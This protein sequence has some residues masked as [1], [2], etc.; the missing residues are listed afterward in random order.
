MSTSTHTEA[1]QPSDL[2]L[3]VDH[4][5]ALTNA[6]IRRFLVNHGL[7]AG[8]SKSDLRQNINEAIADE[9]LSEQEV[10]DYLDEVTPWG[11][12]H[13]FLY[14]GLP[15]ASHDQWKKP[16][17]VRTHL[18]KVGLSS[19]VDAP[20]N[21]LVLPDNLKVAS[22]SYSAKRL[23]VVAVRK[24][25]GWLRDD[26]YDDAGEADD[27]AEI[28]FKAYVHQ[29]LRGMV[30]FEWNLVTNEASMQI[31]QLPS[32]GNYEHAAQEFINEVKPWL[33]ISSLQKLDLQKAIKALHAEDDRGVGE[34]KSHALDYGRVS[35]KHV[36]ARSTSTR[37]PLRGDNVID[38]MMTT[39]RKKGVARIGDFYWDLSGVLASGN[40]S[41]AGVRAHVILV[42][43]K[44]RIN[45]ATPTSEEVIR[46]VLQKLRTI[47]V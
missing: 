20:T 40:G 41:H 47:S 8:L 25:D 7:E 16:S 26:S 23:R 12:Q 33:D 39:L 43:E 10:V 15:T 32:N 4:L 34:A 38:T 18:Q 13:V 3:L 17:W 11:K 27:G 22:I 29:I 9:E 14:K 46:H 19:L 24:R 44:N 5:C 2:K 21:A 45:F 1:E 36:S 6:E 28:K 30:I 42:A 37:V 31:T 35:G